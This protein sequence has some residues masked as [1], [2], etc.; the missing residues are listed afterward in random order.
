[1]P[2]TVLQDGGIQVA[3]DT[4]VPMGGTLA[5]EDAGL[6]IFVWAIRDP[7]GAPL[8]KVQL[9]KGWIEDGERRE[10]VLD[11]ACSGGS[12][13]DPATGR[14][15]DNGARVDLGDCSFDED[16]GATELKALWRDDDYSPDQD[17]FYYV[18]VLQNPTCRWS[19]Y[20]SLRL[21]RE[22][23]EDVPATIT[24]MAWSSPVQVKAAP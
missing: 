18:R 6:D 8:Q 16:R 15:E 14:C 13:V 1:L 12:P 9:I 22:P 20:D 19:T 3:Y 21:G 4:G 23:P 11:I 2:Q 10:Q 24:E 17:A 7:D 5:G